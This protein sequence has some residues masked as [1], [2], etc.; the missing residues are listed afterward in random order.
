MVL[1]RAFVV[2]SSGEPL[3]VEVV[4]IFVQQFRKVVIDAQKVKSVHGRDDSIKVLAAA[5]KKD[6][7]ENIRV[8][9][10]KK[11]DSDQ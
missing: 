3:L 6:S 1:D 11:I 5:I 7:N 4:N 2:Q 9:Y 10:L 8:F